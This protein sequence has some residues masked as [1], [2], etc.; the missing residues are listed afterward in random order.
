MKRQ[1]NVK[2]FIGTSEWNKFKNIAKQRKIPSWLLVRN[3][4]IEFI[5]KEKKKNEKE[6]I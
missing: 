2:F 5:N 3:L 4:V 1:T 6:I